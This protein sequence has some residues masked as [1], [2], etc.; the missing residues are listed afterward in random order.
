MFRVFFS[1]DKI[2][3][4]DF[5]LLANVG[6]ITNVSCF[7]GNGIAAGILGEIVVISWEEC[8]KVGMLLQ[9]WRH[10]HFQF[11]NFTFIDQTHAH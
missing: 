11:L 8:W 4:T 5:Q 7:L 9:D 1:A 3:S 6:V 10:F 2:Q